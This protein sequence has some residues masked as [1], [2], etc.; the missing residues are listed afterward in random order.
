MRQLI[1][2]S[3]STSSTTT[4]AKVPRITALV[5]GTSTRA[6]SSAVVMGSSTE[7]I[8]RSGIHWAAGVA[9]LVAVGTLSG[10]S[11]LCE[12]AD[13]EKVNADE[14]T[15][16]ATTAD[17]SAELNV[18]AEGVQE[19]TVGTEY[20]LA[21]EEK[22]E[23]DPYANLPEEDEET[24]CS[25][26][27]TFRKGPCRPVWRKLERCFKDH[28]HEEN[29]AV[30][31]MRY[32]T[33]HSD[34]LMK[35]TNL[36]HL[37]SLDFKQELIE[38][39]Q[40]STSPEERKAWTPTVDWSNWIM[41]VNEV[42][43]DFQQ[44]IPVEEDQKTPLWQQV[45]EDTEPVLITIKAVIP[46]QQQDESGL[47]LKAAYAV[48]QDGRV[49]GFTFS[50][51]Y[52]EK[53]QEVREVRE[54]REAREAAALKET[55]ASDE[56][57]TTPASDEKETEKEPEEEASDPV[58]EAREAAAR[59]ETPASDE[60]ETTPA[61][62]EKET[63]KEFEEEASD[64]TVSPFEFFLLPGSTKEVRVCALYAE[65]PV[66]APATKVILDASLMESATI[67]LADLVVERADLV[68]ERA[69]SNVPAPN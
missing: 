39:V 52:G 12:K 2:Q 32:W 1:P 5:V 18:K 69:P 54:A 31:C 43:L 21:T 36:Y 46:K 26:C 7:D 63:E 16:T 22:E 53:L 51:E 55:P 56:K 35:H 3:V 42:G 61:S 13:D 50:K 24:G 17:D 29:G 58:R 40:L 41:F 20:Q 34:C 62:D 6:L 44:T 47:M 67:S 59:K 27:N 11:A 57:E 9:A 48:D 38:D 28:E 14:V 66:L 30:K 65:D 8:T 10:A 64:P 15:A 25:M 33:P 68:A 60:K 49:L 45:P 23:E 4:I 37:I 19:I